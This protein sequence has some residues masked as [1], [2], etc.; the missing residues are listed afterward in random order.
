[1]PAKLTSDR[2]KYLRLGRIFLYLFVLWGLIWFGTEHHPGVT[3]SMCLAEPMRYDGAVIDVGNEA[4]V[5]SVSET[6]FA[7]RYLNRTIQVDGSLPAS[8][9]GQYIY[10]KAR[11]IAS[12][13]LEALAI[14]I[15]EQ[16]RSK[17]ILSIFPAVIILFWF[18]RRFRLNLSA[19]I[20]EER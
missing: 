5:Q 15:A 10:L 17:I 2:A 6:T 7:I 16:R 12:D 14:R 20:F 11:F 13:R 1:L 18:F 8:R 4:V 9:V 19:M 3:L